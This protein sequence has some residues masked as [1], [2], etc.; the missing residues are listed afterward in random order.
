MGAIQRTFPTGG[1][2]PTE[3]LVD[4][5]AIVEEMLLRTYA[6]GNSLIL[7]SP[8][9]TGKTSVA[10]ELLRRVREAG[11]LGVYIDC[12]RTDGDDHELAE[13][14][15]RATYD[16]IAGSKGAFARL[17]GF[18]GAMPKPALMQGD[19]D[20][21]LMFFG[22]APETP[23][24][25]LEK[26][27]TLA[28][29]IAA[30][31]GKRVVVVYD[32]FQ[33]LGKVSPT[34]FNPIRAALQHAMGNA[35]YVFMGSEVGLLDELFKN[36][37]NMPFGLATPVTLRQPDPEAWKNYIEA[38]FMEFRSPLRPGEAEEL[39]AFAG[40][41]PRDLMEVC[42]QLLLIRAIS[43]RSDGAALGLAQ[44]NTLRSLRSRFDEVW[45][46]IEKPS[47]TQITAT[48]IA[49]G[50]PVYDDRKRTH[51][52][53]ARSIEAMERAGVIRRTGRGAYEFCEPLFG[54]YVR[55]LSA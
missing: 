51:A 4:R 49:L 3:D 35:A 14:V 19:L 11:G 28:D 10:Y 21:A 23:R 25:L 37:A 41:Y 43:P 26:A 53:V 8:R 15:A 30:Q 52:S 33:I 50:R 7:S 39:I 34:I 13:M 44:E 2:V 31:K 16:Q 24:A 12:S 38:R 20:L 17:R 55:D 6:H 36:P 1:A 48:R 45:K 46:R 27:L 54:R 29:E 32:E 9:Q 40:G 22:S 18:M 47:G 42:E 5:D